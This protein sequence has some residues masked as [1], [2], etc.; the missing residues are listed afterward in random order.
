MLREQG[1]TLRQGCIASGFNTA[2]QPQLSTAD[3]EGKKT[4]GTIKVPVVK[5]EL[6]RLAVG[7]CIQC[8]HGVWQASAVAAD[9]HC[10]DRLIGQRGR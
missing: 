8:E 9:I 4:L 1:L 7:I 2:I 3:D 6:R 5:D 10:D